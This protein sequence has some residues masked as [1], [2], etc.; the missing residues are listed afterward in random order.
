MR[1]VFSHVVRVKHYIFLGY[2]ALIILQSS[3]NYIALVLWNMGAD[4]SSIRSMMASGT[5]PY[6]V[7]QSPAIIEEYS[8]ACDVIVDGDSMMVHGEMTIT[9]QT[10]TTTTKPPHAPPSRFYSSAPRQSPTDGV[11]S[12]RRSFAARDQTKLD[13]AQAHKEVDLKEDYKYSMTT[14]SPSTYSKARSAVQQQAKIITSPTRHQPP[15]SSPGPSQHP[16]RK[17]QVVTKEPDSSTHRRVAYTLS[18]AMF[19]S[20][21]SSSSRN[22]GNHGNSSDELLVKNEDRYSKAELGRLANHTHRKLLTRTRELNERSKSC[23]DLEK[24]TTKMRATVNRMAEE[25]RDKNRILETQ[26]KELLE[27]ES[28]GGKASKSLN[29]IKVE[30]EAC[31]LKLR[32]Q[33]REMEGY[34]RV[35]ERQEKESDEVKR[36]L[37]KTAGRC[38]V[39]E[40][41]LEE[42]L[43]ERNRAELLHSSQLQNR[44]LVIS[45]LEE[46]LQSKMEKVNDLVRDKRVVEQLLY[47]ARQELKEKSELLSLKERIESTPVAVLTTTIK[48]ER[49]VMKQQSAGSSPVKQ[50]QHVIAS[51]VKQQQQV[52]ASPV[53]C[54]PVIQTAS[55]V[56]QDI[57][58]SQ[59]DVM[60][61]QCDTVTSHTEELLFETATKKVAKETAKKPTPAREKAKKSTP[62]AIK[63]TPKKSTIATPDVLIKETPKKSTDLAIS[64]TPRANKGGRKSRTSTMKEPK[65]MGRPRKS[66][67]AST[68]TTEEIEEKRPLTRRSLAAT[69]QPDPL[70]EA[71]AVAPLDP[72]ATLLPDG[73]HCV[74]TPVCI[75]DISSLTPTAETSVTPAAVSEEVTGKRKRKP[76][77]RYSPTQCRQVP[78]NLCLGGRYRKCSELSDATPPPPPPTVHKDVRD[79]RWR[80]SAPRQSPTDGVKSKRRSFAARDQ[81]KLD[82]AQAH[83]EVDLKEDYKYSMTTYSPS[84]YSKARSAVQQQAKIITSPTRPPPSSPGPSQ[85]PK[86]KKQVVTKEPDSST[87]RR[88]AYTLSDAMFSSPPSS[89]S[90]H[91]GNHGNSSDELLVKNEDRYSKAE[92]GRLAN[93]THR[94]LLTRTRELNE[95][96]K[97]CKDLEKTTTKMRATVNRMAEELRDKNRILETQSKELLEMESRGGKASKSLNKVKV[98]LESCQLKLRTQ[99]RE[100][101][102]YRRVM[103]RQEKESDEVK[104]D[105]KKIAGRCKV[106]ENKL[107][108]VLDERNR[109]ELLHSSQLQ[110]RDLVISQLEENLQSKMEKVNDLVRDKR[111]VEQLLYKARQELK[112]KSELLSLKER[113]E[114]TPVTVLTTTIKAERAVMKQQSAG[115]SPVKQQQHV[116]ASPVKQ[117]QQVIASPVKCAPVIQTASPVKQDIVTSQTDVMTSQ[118]DT[119]TSHTEEEDKQETTSGRSRSKRRSAKQETATKKVAK[120]TAKKPTPA[121]EKAKKSTPVAIKE[122][123]KKS[124]IA[125]PDVL[126]KETPKKSTDLAISTTPRANKGGRKSRTSTMKEPKKMGRPRKS[127]VAST[128]TTEEIEEKRPLT[129]RSLAATL[130]PDPLEE[131]DAVA[132]LDPG[133]TLLPDGT[134]CVT[135]PVCID[136]ISSLTPTAETSVTPAAV[137]EE[138]TGKRKRKPASRYS[139]T[140][141]RQVPINLC[142]GGRYRKCSELS[143]A[144]PPPPP[145]TVHKD[146]LEWMVTAITDPLPTLQGHKRDYSCSIE[147]PTFREITIEAL[148]AEEQEQ[149]AQGKCEENADDQQYLKRHRKAEAAEIRMMK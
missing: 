124:T 141:C 62:V 34:R 39:A 107:E 23:K 88:V 65:K 25:L 9:E 117:Q 120:E 89:S 38:K 54:A 114:S 136:D 74:T 19:S 95:R 116:I 102:G 24:T 80:H 43:D 49:A 28:R 57:V 32:T 11:K 36:D 45:Q 35:M 138:V 29:K 118:C 77:S 16:K 93:H 69:L 58:T 10:T 84:T 143:D 82:I 8:D 113:I 66:S 115:S 41:K 106:A 109:A 67:V 87:H 61:S 110:N 56:K 112:E 31:Q 125:T 14:Y 3:V 129:R 134:H 144:T 122:T 123:P 101:E 40:N 83:K 5:E 44:D 137:S 104:R 94:K 128:T 148:R 145:P 147:V 135:T 13:I 70:E 50:Q 17:K 7:G 59:T 48:A 79:S 86:R 149:A 111:V 76:A 55:P 4:V 119:V 98:E 105:L 131:A 12:K 15:P 73:T 133:A 132:P 1:P 64:T 46:N 78:I 51:P 68:T 92:L 63:E 30:L 99:E 142:L 20:P 108:E 42:V 53:K 139:P 96:S 126:I 85:H 18:D 130:Q 26:S 27:M 72:G 121:R 146:V 52:I 37:K 6:Q 90:R 100:M 22:H 21:P 81:T 47:K 33:E 140:Q 2:T 127:S 103:E 60:T 97:S 91:H 75:D 71:D